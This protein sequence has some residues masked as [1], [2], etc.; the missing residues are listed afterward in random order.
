LGIAPDHR[1][2]QKN[3]N[4]NDNDEKKKRRVY[5]FAV[6]LPTDTGATL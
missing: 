4:N 3:I 2:L 1:A 5:L 6:A